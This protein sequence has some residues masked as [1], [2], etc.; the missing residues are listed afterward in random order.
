M[1]DPI[2]DLAN[3]LNTLLAESFAQNFAALPERDRVKC[4]A[5]QDC[6]RVGY[7]ALALRRVQKHARQTGGCAPC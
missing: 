6:Q 3:K 4:L 7:I 5:Q 2:D 1:L